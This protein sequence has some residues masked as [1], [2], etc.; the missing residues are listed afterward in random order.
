MDRHNIVA[1]SSAAERN[2][3]PIAEALTPFLTERS[4]TLLEVASGAGVHAAYLANSFPHLR[5]QPTDLYDESLAVIDQACTGLSNVAP[6]VQLDASAGRLPPVVQPCSLAAVLVVNMTHI[7]PWA[8]TTGLL[9]LASDG[10]LDGGLLF[11]YGPFTVDG[12]HTSE[13]NASFDASLRS[14]D[15]AWGYRDVAA[16]FAEGE[17]HGLVRVDAIG[18]PANNFLLVMRRARPATM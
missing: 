16:V 18:M 3:G 9:A 12:K 2:R 6:A 14:R 10:L 1:S 7:A 15:S 5:F 8:A 17:K 4:G 11:I 13:G